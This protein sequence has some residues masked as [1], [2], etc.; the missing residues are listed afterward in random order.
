[1]RIISIICIAAACMVT[2][3]CTTGPTPAQQQASLA[4]A[5]ARNAMGT[6]YDGKIRIDGTTQLKQQDATFLHSVAN[7][8]NSMAHLPL[9]MREHTP[10][11]K[12]VEDVLG[13]RGLLYAGDVGRASGLLAPKSTAPFGLQITAASYQNE[14]LIQDERLGMRIVDSMAYGNPVRITQQMLDKGFYEIRASYRFV[15]AD[16]ATNQALADQTVPVSTMVH[17]HRD[18]RGYV[19]ERREKTDEQMLREAVHRFLDELIGTVA[20]EPPLG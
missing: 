12:A 4:Q 14:A 5:V 1:M 8:D 20:A 18:Q 11:R 7:R 19:N 9:V 10:M 16:R 6:P 15:L 3:A 17:V 13:N 2:A